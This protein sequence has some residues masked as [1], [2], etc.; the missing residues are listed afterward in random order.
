MESDDVKL[1]VSSHASLSENID[2]LVDDLFSE[3]SSEL[4]QSD[5][6]SIKETFELPTLTGITPPESADSAPLNSKN[7]ASSDSEVNE[8]L[9]VVADKSD[10]TNLNDNSNEVD[11]YKNIISSNLL[12]MQNCAERINMLELLFQQTPGYKQLHSAAKNLRELLRYQEDSFQRALQGDFEEKE[13][14]P[15]FPA[16]QWKLAKKP[17]ASVNHAIPPYQSVLIGKWQGSPAAFIHEEMVHM[18]SEPIIKASKF[19]TNSFYPFKSLKRHPWSK[20][21]PLFVGTLAQNSE[22]ELEKMEVPIFQHPGVLEAFNEPVAKSYL[23]LLHNGNKGGAVF[24][25]SRVKQVNVS[26][27]WRWKEEQKTDSGVIGYFIAEGIYI[28]LISLSGH[29]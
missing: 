17:F 19:V 28:P 24:L 20:I 22:Q 26:S 11:V 18:S 8:D 1:K 13:H 6:S 23:L 7:V 27:Q 12:L 9:E 16:R 25:D 21:Q 2:D 5:S 14:P 3:L 10:L 29:E 15:L 4:D